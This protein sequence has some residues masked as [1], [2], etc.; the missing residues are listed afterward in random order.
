MLK[1][2]LFVIMITLKLLTHEAKAEVRNLNDLIEKDTV[3][4]IQK[5]NEMTIHL[6][7]TLEELK[8][9]QGQ[10]NEAVANEARNKGFKVM[11]RN[12]AA[13]AAA[14]GVAGTILYQVKGVNPSKV[15]LAGGYGVSALA[16]YLAW[17]ENKSIR[18]TREEIRKLQ[19]SV[20]DLEGKVEIEKRNLAREIRLLCL[21]QGGSPD[22]CES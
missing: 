20:K 14:V 8:K 6:N 4:R 11:L 7:N 17:M 18:F 13:A 12:A 16:G 21:E 5:I 9:V 3:E 19:D 22:E 1:R 15:I 2:V 10:L